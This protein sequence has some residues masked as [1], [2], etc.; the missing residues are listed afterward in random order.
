MNEPGSAGD[1]LRAMARSY[2]DQMG[3]A[4]AEQ[5]VNRAMARA[6]EPVPR[7]KAFGALAA[8]AALAVSVLALG[9]IM[10][11]GNSD[12]VVSD[13]D[14]VAVAVS[15]PVTGVSTPQVDTPRT[16]ILPTEQLE[17]AL[18]LLEQQ[19]E[20]E[21]AEVVV[22]A[23][24]SIVVTVVDSGDPAVISSSPPSTVPEEQQDRP[25]PSSVEGHVPP[26]QGTYPQESG[27][28]DSQSPDPESTEGDSPPQQ[29][30]PT[31]T[32]SDPEPSIEE[33]GQVLRVEVEEL[34]S[35]DPQD[36]AE[37][38]EDARN[39]AQQIQDYGGEP[40]ILNP[41]SGDDE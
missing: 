11:V 2:R 39:A 18:N 13:P 35:A 17:E 36:L 29:S 31:S 34:L 3:P 38:A 26:E 27:L 30:D 23:L 20:M 21:A 9:L 25:N 8:S 37:E 6:A 4:R 16:P 14:P 7:F 41:S 28:D 22:R 40:T 33:L 12:P 1:I 19:R 32:T 10:L 5:L 24:S 15:D